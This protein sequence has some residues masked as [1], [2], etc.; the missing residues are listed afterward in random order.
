MRKYVL[1]LSLIFAAIISDA[2]NRTATIRT[3][4]TTIAPG[5]TFSASDTIITSG[6]YTVTITNPQRY[7]QHQTFTTTLSVGSGSPSVAITA[8]GKVTSGGSWVQIGD[9]VTWTSTGNN[10]VA[11]TSAAPLNY[12]YL[13]VAYVCSG[14]TQKVAVTSFEAK[15]ANVYD[16]GSASAYVFGNGTGTVAINSSD[17][18]ISATGVMT[19]MG[20]STFDGAITASAGIITPTP[21]PVIWAKGGSTVLATSGTDAAFS[22]GGRFWVE[23]D[24]PYNVTLTGVAVLVGSVGGTDSLVV[25]LCNSTGVQVATSRSVGGAAVIVGTAAQF[26]SV[27]FTSTYAAV[28]GK[29][30]ACIQSNGTTAKFRAYPIPGS[31]FIANTAAGTWGTKADITPGTTFVAD[32][33]PIVMT[34]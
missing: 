22:N 9:P 12:N 7:L 5:L 14:A 28:A 30:F 4:L 16:V 33:G 27:A 8:Y 3:G 11:I 1:L 18:D 20:A 19:G 34:Y 29:Y 21:S 6:T 23:V 2:A 24:I 17:W 31:K 25:Q 32:K 26:Q 10:P 13:K 15:T